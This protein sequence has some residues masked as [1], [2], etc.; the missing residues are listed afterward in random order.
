MNYEFRRIYHSITEAGKITGAVTIFGGLLYNET[1][2]I[3]GTGVLAGSI[4]LDCF[5]SE[6]SPEDNYRNNRDSLD[7][8]L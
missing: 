4:V 3:I 6:K 2:A 8:R 7:K 1:I 5:F